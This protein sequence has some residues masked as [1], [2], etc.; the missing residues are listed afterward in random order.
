MLSNKYRY[1]TVI[2]AVIIV[3]SLFVVYQ[4]SAAR[5]SVT[6]TRQG[7]NFYHIDGT[8][9]YIETIMCIELALGK[10]AMIEINSNGIYK[11]LIYFANSY[12]DTKS[13]DI[14]EIY[15]A[16]VPVEKM[17]VKTL[18]GIEDVMVIYKPVSLEE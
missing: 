4:V 11:G 18:M 3:L 2:S 15:E 7:Q 1:L 14:V 17:K 6:V 10:K 12:G 13:Y 9:I 5:Y 16:E 8:N